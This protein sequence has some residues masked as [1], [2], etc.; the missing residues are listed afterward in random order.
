MNLFKLP[1][2]LPDEE[3]FETLIP[4]KGILIERIVSTGQ[5][6]PENFWYNQERDEWVVLLQGKA[7][8]KWKDGK[9]KTMFAGDW[10]FI[11]AGE[12]HRVDFTSETP[13]CIWL[14]VH[15]HM[16]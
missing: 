1:E 10:I 11:P 5:V 13:P 9:E 16:K 12:S 15:G 2:V 14:A 3:I 8:I 4:D 6:S 7:V